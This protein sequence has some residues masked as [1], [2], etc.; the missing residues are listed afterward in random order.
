MSK[1]RRFGNAI[2]K[3][4]LLIA[5]YGAGMATEIALNH[6]REAEIKS[7]THEVD[8][9]QSEINQLKTRIQKLTEGIQTVDEIKKQI[10]VLSKKVDALN[11]FHQTER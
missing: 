7:L 9:Q 5:F 10:L 3:L 1:W 4:I 11:A 6:H 2:C 8:A